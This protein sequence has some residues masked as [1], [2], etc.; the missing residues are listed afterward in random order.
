MDIYRG[1]FEQIIGIYKLNIF[2]ARTG[3]TGS[4]S[5]SSGMFGSEGYLLG[6]EKPEREFQYFGSELVERYKTQFKRDIINTFEYMVTNKSWWDTIDRIAK[7]SIGEYFKTY[8]EKK[9]EY[10]DKWFSSNEIWLQRCCLLFQL[11]YKE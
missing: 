2:T 4:S 6:I 3:S 10:M 1:P 9:D 8:P 11:A 5:L 7:K